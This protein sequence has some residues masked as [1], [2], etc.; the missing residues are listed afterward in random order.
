MLENGSLYRTFT[1][2]LSKSLIINGACDVLGK[3]M[4]NYLQVP[5]VR[6]GF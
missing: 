5:G 6:D 2:L 4:L 3:M 1:A